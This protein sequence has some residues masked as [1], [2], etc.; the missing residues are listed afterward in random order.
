[1]AVM[2]Q[3]LVPALEDARQTHAAVA[4][5]FRADV[6]V[7]PPGPYRQMLERQV[8]EVLDSLQRIEHH[9]RETRPRGLIG[10]T[11]DMA[12]LVSRSAMRAAMLPL[13]IGTSLVTGL[14]GGRQANELRLLKNAEHEFTAAARALAASRAGE[15]IAEEIQDQAAADLLGSLRRQDQ[16]LLETLEDSVAAH[17]RAVVAAGNGFGPDHEGTVLEEAVRLVRTTA[18]RL[19][20]IVQTSGRQTKSAAEGVVREMPGV[21]RMAEEVQG[22][23][24]REE[25]LPI[26]GYGRLGLD[27]INKRLRPLSQ[28]ELTVIEGYERAHANRDA[29]LDAIEQL[30][31]SEPWPGYD[32]MAPSDIM[33]ELQNVSLSVARKVAEYEQH[34]R[35]R[36][37]VIS[38]AQSRIPL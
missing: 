33:A 23:V 20:D 26:A 21:T 31:G 27:E 4:D 7:T 38:A 2:T 28:S 3:A 11:I 16:E 35:R 19:R 6:T 37:P 13:A 14:L 36:E 30:R 25:D 32:A 9:V 29:V 8:A 5:R 34:H 10:T 24:T 12:G 15:S 17:A 22:A 1:M 18:D